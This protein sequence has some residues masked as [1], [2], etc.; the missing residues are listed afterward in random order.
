MNKIALVA[1]REY[2]AHITQR[3]FWLMTLFLPILFGGG[4]YFFQ[5]TT[6]ENPSRGIYV[7]DRSGRYAA[8]FTDKVAGITYISEKEAAF[9]NDITPQ[10]TFYIGEENDEGIPA[11]IFYS[12]DANREETKQLLMCLLSDYICRQKLQEMP[13][14]IQARLAVS[15]EIT[16]LSPIEN[17]TQNSGREYFDILIIISTLIYLFIFI[18]SARVL[19]STVQE[20]SNRILEILLTSVKARDLIYGKIIAIALCGITQFLLWGILLGLF[21]IADDTATRDYFA[22]I[23]PD[24]IVL[25]LL[26][27]VG[28]Y[29]LYAALFAIVGAYINPDTDNRQFVLPLTFLSLVAFYI[30]LYSLNDMSGSVAAWCTYIPFTSPLL[31]VTRYAYGLSVGETLLSLLLLFFFAGICIHFASRIYQSRLL[32]YKKR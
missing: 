27:F 5:T 8:A 26:C 21:V 3:A 18:Y 2:K 15:L 25:F 6:V 23:T 30:G 13:S 9:P 29:L 31:L 19:Q 11:T 32:S 17:S 4:Y 22:F 24:W 12:T 7:I 16:D 1:R 28:G 20:K 14:D 10:A